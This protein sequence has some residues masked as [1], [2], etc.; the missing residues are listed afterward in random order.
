MRTIRQ[1]E[2]Q[3]QCPHCNALL[4]ITVNDIQVDDVGHSLPPYYCKCPEC[5]IMGAPSIV[6]IK[7]AQI[8]SH[9]MSQLPD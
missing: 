8:P 3:V 6:E 5:S 4:G 7:R 1:S 9:I 2:I